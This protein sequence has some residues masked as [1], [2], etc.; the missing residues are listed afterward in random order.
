[1]G[2]SKGYI[3][4][5][6]P[7]WTQT[8]RAITSMLKSPSSSTISKV[9]DRYANALQVDN[10]SSSSFPAAVS[11]FI[12][13]LNSVR[14]NG[15]E[16]ALREHGFQSLIGKPSSEIM[17]AIL[18]QYSNGN[19]TIDDNLL[20]DCLSKLMETFQI[21]DL[22][23]FN[24]VSNEELLK[25]LVID[26]IQLK[27]EQLYEEKIRANRTPAEGSRIIAEVKDYLRDHLKDSL[28][29]NDL[30]G[31]DFLNIQGQNFIIET[32]RSAYAL[33]RTYDEE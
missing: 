19:G 4:P 10:L 26:Y 22:I 7:E 23:D 15:V 25:E 9:V 18:Y 32:C 12:G 27:F 30:T 3:A 31:I 24:Q 5:T 13:L 17:N 6:K 14:A 28:T 8:K 29:I 21:N 1:M 11:G 2:T 16:N 33:L 20:I